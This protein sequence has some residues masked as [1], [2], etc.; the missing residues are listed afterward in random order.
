MANF[1][2]ILASA[3]L[4]E[5]AVEICLRG[6]LQRR[7]EDLE[8]DLQAAREADDRAS[9]LAEGGQA[10]KVAE[11]IQR[12]EAEMREHTHPFAFRALPSREYRELVQEHP[13]REGDQYDA[14]YG[15]NM[16]TFPSVLISRCCIDPPMTVEQVEQL[17]DVLTDGQ[18]TELFLCAARVNR[19]Q[20]DVPK[21]VAA[22][23]ILAS[24]VPKS[25]Q[26]ARGESRRAGSQGGSLAG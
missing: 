26:P 2:D 6:D 7:H 1:D 8:R 25:K 17:C 4:P 10:R 11:E 23:A 3:K 19:D 20:V 18:Q 24:S 22:S 15:A 9:S 14:L 5:D 12:V 13:P 21:S 16:L